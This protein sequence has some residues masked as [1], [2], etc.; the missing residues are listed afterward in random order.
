MW[1][2]LPAK[3]AAQ[4]PKPDLVKQIEDRAADRAARLERQARQKELDQKIE[5]AIATIVSQGISREALVEHLS[6]EA[7]DNADLDEVC[8]A[9]SGD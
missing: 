4:P 8:A 5:A 1:L 6:D 7:I 9:K 3:D 2:S